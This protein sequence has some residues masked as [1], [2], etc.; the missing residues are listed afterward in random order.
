MR[1]RVHARRGHNTLVVV[2]QG[3][4]PPPARPGLAS[5]TASAQNL[6]AQPHRCGVLATGASGTNATGRNSTH[7]LPSAP[8][9]KC[10][11]F[12]QAKNI[13]LI[14]SVPKVLTPSGFTSE[15]QVSSKLGSHR[16]AASVR[17]SLN[18]FCERGWQEPAWGGRWRWRRVRRGPG[19]HSRRRRD[20][21]PARPERPPPRSS[22]PENK[23]L[24][25]H[26]LGPGRIRPGPRG[27]GSRSRD[28]D[29]W[30]SLPHR[31]PSLSPSGQ[32]GLQCRCRCKIL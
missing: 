7:T 24:C 30:P 31:A 28:T 8:R 23:P 3:A 19:G 32:A 16:S 10:M 11:S 15:S 9:P 6:H 12:S 27:P 2:R 20:R 4:R 17:F 14:W 25:V 1:A 21:P 13:H 18:S 5:L 26:A 22:R 29:P